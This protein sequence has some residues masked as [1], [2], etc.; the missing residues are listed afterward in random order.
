MTQDSLKWLTDKGDAE[1]I[2]LAELEAR[3]LLGRSEL[4]SLR[5]LGLRVEERAGDLW[6]KAGELLAYG[7]ELA[8]READA[9][10]DALTRGPTRFH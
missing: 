5:A 8:V 6:M 7:L 2:S 1:E 9:V 3:E 4:D 10:A